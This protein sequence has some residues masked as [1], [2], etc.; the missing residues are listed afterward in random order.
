MNRRQPSRFDR[1]LTVIFLTVC[2]AGCAALKDGSESIIRVQTRQDTAKASRLTLQGVK[3]MDSGDTDAAVNKF[4]AAI[5]SD[6]AYGP[7]H[8]NL[9]LLHYEQGNLYQAVLAFER[10]MELMPNDPIVYYNLGLT[11]QAAGKVYEALDLYWQ[12]VEIDPAN[13]HF[14]GNLVRLRIQLGEEGPEIQTQLQD[15]ALIETRSGWRRWADDQLA[16]RFN[17]SLDRGPETPDFN[18]GRKERR[19]RDGDRSTDNVIDLTPKNASP[20]PDEDEP[21][22]NS[23]KSYLSDPEIVPSPKFD[24]QINAP[25]MQSMH[26]D[27]AGSYDRHLDDG[28]LDSGPLPIQNDGSFDQLPPSIE[29]MP[30][31]TTDRDYFRN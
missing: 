29:V 13:P 27:D 31:P 17:D 19:D 2:V 8:N 3:A 23:L 10:A 9:G 26:L 5:A 28:R 24:A 12:A 4:L 22:S 20:Q 6:E 16:I 18:S 30:E 25:R 11:L 15:L 21:K 1:A 7:A 14:L